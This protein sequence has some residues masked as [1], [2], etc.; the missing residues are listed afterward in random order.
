MT[1]IERIDRGE[2]AI[3]LA[4]AEGRDVTAWETHLAELKRKAAAA[5][6]QNT[7]LSMSTL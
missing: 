3:K 1:L 7:H 5:A 2:A 6:I 4:M